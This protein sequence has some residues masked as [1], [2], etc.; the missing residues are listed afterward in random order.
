MQGDS[1]NQMVTFI[2]TQG[3]SGGP[4]TV[5]KKGA[6]F[7]VGIVSRRLGLEDA[8]SEQDYAVFTNVSALLPWIRTSIE[9]NG[10]MASCSFNISAPPTL[11]MRHTEYVS[12]KISNYLTSQ[13][14]IPLQFNYINKATNI[15]QENHWSLPLRLV[16]WC[17]AANQKNHQK[18]N[19]LPSRPLAWRTVQFLLYRKPDMVLDPSSP[20][21]RRHS[22][23]YVVG[24]GW[25]NQ[26]PQIVSHSMLRL[27]C[28]NEAHSPM[29]SLE[30][31]FEV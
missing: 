27:L 6:H 18:D 29:D 14:L 11:G 19:L 28:G 16:F 7:L 17:L 21:P 5:N 15:V 12:V 23:L 9:E 8:C 1:S 26:T 10:G 20:P 24:G 30:M 3:D 31:V 4:L 22:W 13:M 25:E 2:Q